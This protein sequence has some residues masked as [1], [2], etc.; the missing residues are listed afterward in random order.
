[1]N[2]EK[3]TEV[4]LVLCGSQLWSSN[5][6]TNKMANS[7]F[8]GRCLLYLIPAEYYTELEIGQTLFCIDGEMVVVEKGLS[9][10]RLPELHRQWQPGRL[11]GL[12][13]ADT[14]IKDKS[15]DTHLE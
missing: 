1:M 8:E 12:W 5:F 7:M 13:G 15:N 4:E 6:R 3:M 9:R 2:F 14:K 10:L 11:L